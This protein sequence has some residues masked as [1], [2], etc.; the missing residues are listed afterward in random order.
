MSDDEATQLITEMYTVRRT[1]INDCDMVAN[2]LE[3]SV[4]ILN[5]IEIIRGWMVDE[6]HPKPEVQIP[7]VLAGFKKRIADVRSDLVPR[8]NNL[9]SAVPQHLHPGLRTAIGNLL[10]SC[11]DLEDSINRAELLI[12]LHGKTP[13]I[14]DG[15]PWGQTIDKQSAT[16]VVEAIKGEAHAI[17]TMATDHR[18]DAAG[19]QGKDA[20]GAAGDDLK[21]ND[22]RQDLNEP[23]IYLVCGKRVYLGNDTNA[24]RFFCALASDIGR[25]LTIDQITSEVDGFE[26]STRV[27]SSP[28][29]IRKARQRAYKAANEVKK[30]LQENGADD[31]LMLSGGGEYTLTWRR[32][33]KGKT[34]TR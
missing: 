16:R 33:E 25:P 17:Q 21:T 30:A 3:A 5:D 14:L 1:A 19:G 29:D 28:D 2:L 27:S 4:S 22:I 9:A 10:R 12:K 20:D 13:F 15:P 31:H 7:D 8:M 18:E 6:S 34:P 11:S 32:N 26:T 23:A 24:A